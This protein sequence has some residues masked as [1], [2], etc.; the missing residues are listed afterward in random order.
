MLYVTESEQEWFCDVW[1]TKPDRHEQDEV[2]DGATEKEEIENEAK[3]WEEDADSSTEWEDAATEWIDVW[4]E[5]AEWE[6]FE[7]ALTTCE[8]VE[9]VLTESKDEEVAEEEEEEEEQKE[10]V[11][12][13]VHKTGHLICKRV[14]DMNGTKTRKG[15]RAWKPVHAVLQGVVLHLQKDKSNPSKKDKAITL[16]HALAYPVEYKKRPHALCLRTADLRQFFFQAE[17]KVEQTSWVAAINT[18][19]ACYSAP[20]LI[21]VSHDSNAHCPLLLPSFRSPHFIEEQLECYQYHFL[22]ASNDFLHYNSRLLRN[23]SLSSTYVVQDMMRYST[24][25]RILKK[26]AAKDAGDSFSSWI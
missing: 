10:E 23:G 3:E 19:A 12:E 13:F 21:P 17:N 16:L 11:R 9:G 22:K 4:D 2:V 18:I 25:V 5:A 6:D 14:T 20:P 1:L 26:L 15:Q 8:E 7:D 24:Y